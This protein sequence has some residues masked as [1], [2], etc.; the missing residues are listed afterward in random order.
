MMRVHDFENLR[1]GGECPQN[2]SSPSRDCWETVYRRFHRAG[3]PNLPFLSAELRVVVMANEE[4]TGGSHPSLNIYDA[5]VKG[6]GIG[7]IGGI[8]A[9]HSGVY[10]EAY[11][12]NNG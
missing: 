6:D 1:S 11:E 3:A 10:R 5:S 4:E 8:Q 9:G 7:V 2:L 12:N